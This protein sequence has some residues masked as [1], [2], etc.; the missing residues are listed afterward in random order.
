MSSWFFKTFPTSN[1]IMIFFSFNILI[2]VNKRTK[3]RQ[4]NDLFKAKLITMSQGL[5]TCIEIK[6]MTTN[7]KAV[8]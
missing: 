8:V 6:Y 5:T 4:K 3:K 1:E 2:W 7:G